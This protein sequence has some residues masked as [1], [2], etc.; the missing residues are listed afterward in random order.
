MVGIIVDDGH[1]VYAAF[2]LEPAVGP[3][4][5]RKSFHNGLLRNTQ[6]QGKGDGGERVCD[7]VHAGDV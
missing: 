7:I 5:R 6:F 4:K 1:A 2:V 3:V